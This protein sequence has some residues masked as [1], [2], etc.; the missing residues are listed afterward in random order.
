MSLLPVAHHAAT[1]RLS[2][3]VSFHFLSMIGANQ[4]FFPGTIFQFKQLYFLLY[5]FHLPFKT[6]LLIILILSLSLKILENFLFP[7]HENI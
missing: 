6:V 1:L 4:P 2:S 7:F 3:A 5:K